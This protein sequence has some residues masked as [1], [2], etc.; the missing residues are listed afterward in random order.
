MQLVILDNEIEERNYKQNNEVPI[1][2]LTQ[3][4]LNKTMI[5]EPTERGMHC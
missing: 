4:R 1:K 5:G 3:K 2:M